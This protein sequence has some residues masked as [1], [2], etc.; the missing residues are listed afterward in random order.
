M[1]FQ[2]FVPDIPPSWVPKLTIPRD[3]FDMR[4]PRGSK[5]TLFN[6]CQ[7]EIFALFGDCNRY[8]GMVEKIVMYAVSEDLSTH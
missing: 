4:C 1:V 8:D 3:A 7:R 6:K 5:L 2:D